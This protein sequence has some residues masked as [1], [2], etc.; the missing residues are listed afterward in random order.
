MSRK[1]TSHRDDELR[2]TALR[3]L[4][5]TYDCNCTGGVTEL[6][7]CVE[8]A[9]GNPFSVVG[10]FEQLPVLS[11]LKPLAAKTMEKKA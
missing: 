3:S 11:S 1:P 2:I 6:V 8:R 4:Y 10:V 7:K 9:S 5:F